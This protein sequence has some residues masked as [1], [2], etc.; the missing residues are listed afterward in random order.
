MHHVVN[1][2]SWQDRHFQSC[3]HGPLDDAQ[4]WK[5]WLKPN[6]RAHLALKNVVLNNTLLRDIPKLSSFCHTGML[7]VFHSLLTK[8][9]PKRQHFS[10]MGMCVCTELA[11][12]DHNYNIEREQ[13]T[14]S[15]DIL[16]YKLEFS[17][18]T[19]RWV[20]KPVKET[21][22]YAHLHDM[23]E[24]LVD[25]TFQEQQDLDTS[26]LNLPSNIAKVPRPNKQDVINQQMS[27]FGS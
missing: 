18:A 20:A 6:G 12:L 10:L 11:I 22:S 19:K 4:C 5:E 7:E 14:T 26:E 9:C 13:A 16:Q 23:L 3:E 1:V 25:L 24:L 15:E 8:Y 2:H 21:K 17:K 27:R